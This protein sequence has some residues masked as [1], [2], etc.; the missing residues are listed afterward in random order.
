MK[1]KLLYIVLIILIIFLFVSK[2]KAINE[3]NSLT[4]RVRILK[5]IDSFVIKSN[6]LCQILDFE[7]KTVLKE[8]TKIKESIVLALNNNIKI[9]NKILETNNIFFSSSN[10]IKINSIFYKGKMNIRIEKGKLEVINYLDIEEYLK[11]V[12]PKEISFLWPLDV[13][14]AQ[15]IASR[16]FALSKIYARK[17]KYYDLENNTYS[18]VYGGK[19]CEKNKTTKAVLETKDMVLEYNGKVLPA[20]FHSCCGGYTQSSLRAWGGIVMC[21]ALNGVKCS[22]C[23]WSPHYHW[24]TKIK[25]QDIEEQLQN[26]KIIFGNIEKIKIGEKDVSGRIKFLKIKSEN[27]WST[28]KIDSFISSFGG[29][30]LKSTNFSLK[31]KGDFFVFNGYGWG[32]GVGMCQWG[33]FALSIKGWS[34]KKILKKYYPYS[35]IVNIKKLK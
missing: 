17:N 21:K 27:K 2:N 24:K 11:G 34:F 31:Q 16:S 15:A 3:Q 6:G 23:K 35:K 7:T 22:Y 12:L 33:A 8:K 29:K 32:H 19:S 10:L 18:Q 9:G 30:I 5:D 13:M 20:Y 28:V 1:N 26:K 25:K 14:K 4:I